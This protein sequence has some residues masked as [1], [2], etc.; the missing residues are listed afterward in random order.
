[1]QEILELMPHLKH[2]LELIPVSLVALF[3]G[4]ISYFNGVDKAQRSKSYAIKVII[5][6]AF[7]ALTA[8]TILSATD[9]PYLAKVGISAMIGF[10][11]IDKTIELVQKLLSLKNNGGKKE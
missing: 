4:I 1:M 7:L 5:T 3:A 9:L 2:Y 8:Y 10:F 11:G 6:S